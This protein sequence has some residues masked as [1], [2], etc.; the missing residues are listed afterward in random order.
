MTAR[1]SPAGRSEPGRAEKGPGL[2]VARESAKERAA[3]AQAIARLLRQAYPDAGCALVHGSAWELLVATILSAQCTDAMV[4]RVTP[5]L[6]A[7]Y[8]TPAAL[9]AAP[10][11]RV[12]LLV[13][14]TGFFRQ[15]TK[16]IQGVARAVA[17]RPGGRVPETMEELVQLPGI[18]RKT[19]NVVLGTAFGQPSI[20]V[21][22]HV[23]RLSSRLGLTVQGEPEKIERDLQ[24]LLPPRIWTETAHRLIHHGRQICGA[25]KPRCS[26]CPLARHCA[27][28]GVTI[29]A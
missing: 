4:N 12:E 21:D 20:F 25:R 13:Q 27:Q 26:H 9:A 2:N 18:G 24:I 7:E 29:S 22:T 14:R 15:K 3:R 11:A 19:A 16:A 10:T 1:R 17:A 5:G 6:F 23:R 28:I 8:P